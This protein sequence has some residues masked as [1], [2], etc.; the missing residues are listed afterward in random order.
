[1]Q[2]EIQPKA[3]DNVDVDM[4]HSRSRVCQGLHYARET[5]HLPCVLLIGPFYCCFETSLGPRRVLKTSCWV[6]MKALL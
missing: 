2:M 3:D 4:G 6:I 1:M 5:P